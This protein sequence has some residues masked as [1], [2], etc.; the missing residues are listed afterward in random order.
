MFI[1]AT[2]PLIART[3]VNPVRRELPGRDSIKAAELKAARDAVL[4]PRDA[5]ERVIDSVVDRLLR[6]LTW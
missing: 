6:E 5:K 2:K 1:C 3:L 4:D